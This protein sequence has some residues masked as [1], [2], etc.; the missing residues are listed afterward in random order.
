[1]VLRIR[2]TLAR[3]SSWW[4][5]SYIPDCSTSSPGASMQSV[6]S[7]I[8]VFLGAMLLWLCSFLGR[9]RCAPCLRATQLPQ[10]RCVL[11]SRKLV[12][13]PDRPLRLHFYFQATPEQVSQ[14]SQALLVRFAKAFS[15]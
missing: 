7:K 5:T 11:S 14:A 10:M 2:I 1:M 9:G 8:V 12:G 3:G 6:W 15:G 4:Q 13:S